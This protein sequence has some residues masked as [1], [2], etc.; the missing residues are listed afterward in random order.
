[1]Y[2]YNE[3][4]LYILYIYIYMC[5]CM[6]FPRN[7]GFVG[8]CVCNPWSNSRNFPLIRIIALLRNL[9]GDIDCLY[10]ISRNKYKRSFKDHGYFDKFK[11]IRIFVILELF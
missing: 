2:I 10:V 8:L 3:N 11:K 7:S 1:M 4:E 5:V 9:I 6:L